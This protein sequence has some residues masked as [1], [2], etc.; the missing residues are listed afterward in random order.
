MKFEVIFSLL[1]FAVSL[2]IFIRAIMQSK[3]VNLFNAFGLMFIL[4]FLGQFTLSSLYFVDIVNY[5]D[6]SR[7][8]KAV[9]SLIGGCLF[10]ISI[11]LS[12]EVTTPKKLKTLWRIPILAFLVG[13]LLD[14][15]WCTSLFLAWNLLSFFVV[16]RKKV[17]LRYLMRKLRMPV[18]ISIIFPFVSYS[19][20]VVLLG[21]SFVYL[22]SITSVGRIVLGSAMLNIDYNEAV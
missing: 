9:I 18:A 3:G 20:T 12:L 11:V 13:L 5:I 17:R 2:L 1:F 15:R 8:F 4:S 14:G 7:Y 10:S 22:L 19:E 21:L 16:F 6:F